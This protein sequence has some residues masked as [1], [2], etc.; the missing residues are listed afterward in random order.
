MYIVAIA[1]LYVISMMAITERNFTAGML[2]FVFYGLAPTAL[3]LW[4]AGAKRRHRAARQRDSARL[5]A[6]DEEMHRP[7]GSDTR[8]DQ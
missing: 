3:L 4:L 7:N 1:W 5:V 8:P 6:S 2:T